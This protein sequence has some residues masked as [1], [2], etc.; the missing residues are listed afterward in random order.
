MKIPPVEGELFHADRWTDIRKPIVASHN[1]ANV[2]KNV[3]EHLQVRFPAVT[4][5]FLLSK[6]S[7]LALKPTQPCVAKGT[8][9]SF[10]GEK[11]ATQCS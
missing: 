5:I 7:R 9:G 2:S 6:M 1:F 3:L 4:R 8:G 10:Q 11:T